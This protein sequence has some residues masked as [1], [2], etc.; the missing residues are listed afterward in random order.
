MQAGC[1][2]KNLKISSSLEEAN[3]TNS[4]RTTRN[5]N[6]NSKLQYI[7]C[8]LIRPLARDEHGS[9]GSAGLASSGSRM[10]NIMRD[11]RVVASL[12]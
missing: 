1:I 2:P 10:L 11:I 8:Q 3:A 7:Y 9:R 12:K 6:I 5:P 4:L